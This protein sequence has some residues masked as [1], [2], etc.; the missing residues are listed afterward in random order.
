MLEIANI[1]SILQYWRKS[2]SNTVTLDSVVADGSILGQTLAVSDVSDFGR[3]NHS[4]E[5]LATLGHSNAEFVE[6]GSITSINFYGSL[7]FCPW[8]QLIASLSADLY[9]AHIV[10]TNPQ[11]TS[12]QRAVIELGT[13]AASSETTFFRTSYFQL[14]GVIE[15]MIIPVLPR[16]KI[17]SGT[18]LSARGSRS[19]SAGNHDISLQFAAF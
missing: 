5:A 15:C 18:R 11:P 2:F 17:A 12:D 6:D 14:F 10:I 19:G 4:L 8:T 9:L 13:G 16:R 3:G 7:S 1:E